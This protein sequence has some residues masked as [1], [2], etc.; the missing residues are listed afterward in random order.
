MPGVNVDWD[1]ITNLEGF[2]LNGYIPVDTDGNCLGHSGITISSGV[3]LGQVPSVWGYGLSQDLAEKLALYCNLKGLVAKAYLDQNPLTLTAS[4]CY[5]L[6]QAAHGELLYSLIYHYNTQ[7]EDGQFETIPNK[8]Q[9]VIM[10]VAYQYGAIWQRCPN[11][12]R[13]CK[14]MNWAEV[15]NELRNFGDAYP[16]RRNKEADLLSTLDN[17]S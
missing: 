14:E 8:A 16:T 3:D 1:F 2:S 13:F 5:E 7:T 6:N 12:W 9:T 4:E 11:F 10:S 17:N 15:V